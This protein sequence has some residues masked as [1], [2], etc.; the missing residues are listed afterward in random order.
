MP[1]SNFKSSRSASPHKR[2][3]RGDSG[4]L[5][6]NTKE[7]RETRTRT[8]SCDLFFAFQVLSTKITFGKNQN[9]SAPSRVIISHRRNY[10]A[11]MGRNHYH[12]YLNIGRSQNS[13]LMRS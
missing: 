6:D 1:V 9:Q 4:A 8:P 2:A 7:G 3:V 11:L 5:R 12:A 10:L 13:F